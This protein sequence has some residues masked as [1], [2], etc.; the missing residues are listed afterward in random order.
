MDVLADMLY[1][2]IIIP[3]ASLQRPFIC[4]VLVLPL[5]SGDRCP[6]NAKY[7]ASVEGAAASRPFTPRTRKDAIHNPCPLLETVSTGTVVQV[8]WHRYT[9]ALIGNSAQ[10]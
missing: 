5:G 1:G 4:L 3:A 9:I 2:T 6:F 10:M 7:L 8:R